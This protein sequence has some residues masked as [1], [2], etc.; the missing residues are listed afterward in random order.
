MEY[1]EWIILA[2][3]VGVAVWGKIKFEKIPQLSKES[4]EVVEAVKNALAD[5]NITPDEF[6][7]IVKEVKDVIDNL[8]NG[9]GNE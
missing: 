7:V 8:K 9:G 5:G 3:L 2:G 6:G 4:M 1:G